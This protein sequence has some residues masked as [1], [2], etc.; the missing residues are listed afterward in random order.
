MAW[1]SHGQGQGKGKGGEALGEP[2]H[3]VHPVS[4]QSSV[5]APLRSPISFLELDL[6]SGRGVAGTGVEWQTPEGTEW[7]GMEWIMERPAP[8]IPPWE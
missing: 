2:V 5:P 8:P 7:N 1:A 6:I 3:P 4:P